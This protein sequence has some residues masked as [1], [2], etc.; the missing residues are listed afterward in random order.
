MNIPYEETSLTKEALDHIL[1]RFYG[2]VRTSTATYYKLNSFRSI[3]H[4]LQRYFFNLFT[5]DIINDSEFSKA[6]KSW[7]NV[8]KILK[9]SGKG[10]TE[11][12]KEIEPED[13]RI[14]KVYETIDIETPSGLQKKVWFDIL[15]Y[16]SRRG[17][18]NQRAMTKDTF[19]LNNDVT[20]ATF[21]Y[22]HVDEGDKNHTIDDNSFDTVGEGRM[23]ANPES[24]VIWLDY[25]ETEINKRGCW[26]KN[27]GEK[28]IL[29]KNFGEDFRRN[30]FPPK[31]LGFNVS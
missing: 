3:K 21:V 19:R 14:R 8:A 29:R 28:K 26:N 12:H 10:Q 7:N 2:G 18:E 6:N 11:H 1:V 23:Y 5:W 27:Y 30:F 15:Y 22:Q 13:L 4:G 31:F 25:F 20:G 16:F 17:A 24:K 9:Q